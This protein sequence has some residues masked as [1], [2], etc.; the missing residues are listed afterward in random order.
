MAVR[1]IN[2]TTPRTPAIS[3][4]PPAPPGPP[5]VVKLI[6]LYKIIVYYAR[7]SIVGTVTPQ[8]GKRMADGP[9]AGS[10]GNEAVRAPYRLVVWGTGGMG[11]VAISTVAM[12]RDFE[13]IGARV[14]SADKDGI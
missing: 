9:I 7:I 10:P 12:R 6:V 14:Y 4:P 3:D 8:R 13:I 2:S 5:P 11:R 1:C